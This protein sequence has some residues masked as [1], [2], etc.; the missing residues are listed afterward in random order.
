MACEIISV[1]TY[2]SGGLRCW[3]GVLTLYNVSVV[4][5]TTDTLNLTYFSVSVC[6][7][8]SPKFDVSVTDNF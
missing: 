1:V 8:V 2:N 7:R 3:F 6:R 5:R 4:K